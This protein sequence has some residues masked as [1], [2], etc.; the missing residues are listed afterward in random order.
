MREIFASGG[1]MSLD[2]MNAHFGLGSSN[3]VK[4]VTV[5]WSTGEEDIIQGPF[6]SGREYQIKRQAS[7]ATTIQAP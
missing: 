3:E 7:N 1:F 4:Q 2:P 5:K 6:P